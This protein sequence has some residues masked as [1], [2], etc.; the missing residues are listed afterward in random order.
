M[1]R[2][3]RFQFIVIGINL[4][5]F[6]HGFIADLKTCYTAR[7]LT[8]IYCARHVSSYKRAVNLKTILKRKWGLSRI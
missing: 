4:Y 5:C 8:H 1:I 7:I 6:R 2:S 3:T